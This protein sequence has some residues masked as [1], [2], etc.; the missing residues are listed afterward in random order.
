MP[1]GLKMGGPKRPKLIKICKKRSDKTNPESRREKSLKKSFFSGA[2]TLLIEAPAWA[3]VQ[4]SQN[5]P[6]PEM[7]E[8]GLQNRCQNGAKI[9]TKSNQKPH[10]KTTSQKYLKMF[11]NGL[12]EGPKMTSKSP[13]RA[14]KFGLYLLP[15]I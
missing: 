10:Q 5:Q 12:P 3:G 9:D 8:K 13:P 4:F 1:K 2:Q 6:L 11:Q 7:F 15:V 14:Y